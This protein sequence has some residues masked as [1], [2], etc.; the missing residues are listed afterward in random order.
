M[1]RVVIHSGQ[2]SLE[3]PLGATLGPKIQLQVIPDHASVL[4]KIAQQQVDV[5]VVDLDARFASVED[6]FSFIAQLRTTNL[7]VLVLTDDDCRSTALDLLQ[8][9]VYDYFRKPPS[10]L[11][12]SVVIRR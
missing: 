8:E 5:V 6:Q 12:M 1:I 10:P 2:Q 3:R 7:P 11:E 9:G 4:N